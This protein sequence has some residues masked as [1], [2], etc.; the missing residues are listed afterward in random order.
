[1]ETMAWQSVQARKLQRLSTLGN[2]TKH[3]CDLQVV[4][5]ATPPG[6]PSPSRIM[7]AISKIDSLFTQAEEDPEE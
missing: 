3:R 2:L 5:A 7:D 6:G 1:M 4:L